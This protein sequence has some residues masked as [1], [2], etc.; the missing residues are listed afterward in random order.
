MGWDLNEP[1]ARQGDGPPLALGQPLSYNYNAKGI[2][3]KKKPFHHMLCKH[4]L[5]D[6]IMSGL[7]AHWSVLF[8]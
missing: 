5:I 4:M 7:I 6:F 3:L 1:P 8:V 2:S